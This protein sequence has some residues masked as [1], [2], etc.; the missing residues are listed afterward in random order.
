MMVKYGRIPRKMAKAMPA[1][2]LAA[3]TLLLA[4][5]SGPQG[6][7][8][9]S[10]VSIQK[11]GT[12]LS[13]IEESF[14][15]DYYDLE[16]LQQAILTEAA[17]FNKAAGDDKISVEKIEANEGVVTVR[18]TY[19]EPLDYAAYNHV[20]FY[21]GAAADVPEGYELNVVL[22]GVKDDSQTVGKSDI[23]SM[24]GYKLLIMD[25]PEPVYL[26]GK[27]EYVSGNVAVSPNRKCAQVEGE[28]TGYVLYK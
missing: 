4:S 3:G 27:A 1:A 19:G 14:A 5:C 20:L 23:L 16:E 15:Q 6:G 10:N 2:L 21:A 8:E 13:H 11:D 22:S 17:D 9:G 12:V 7:G 26:D 28:G 18:M 24:E 25:I